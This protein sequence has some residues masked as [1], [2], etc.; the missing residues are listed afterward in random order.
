MET[1]W[2]VADDG[3]RLGYVVDGA[4]PPLVVCHGGPGLADDLGPLAALVHDHVSVVRWDQRGVGRSDPVGPHTIE[5]YVA[6]LDALRRHLGHERWIVG[7]HSFGATIALRYALAH[8]ERTRGLLYLAGVGTG[9]AWPAAAKA[10]GARRLTDEQRARRDALAAGERT[11]AE[12]V[13]WRALHWLPDFVGP[14]AHAHATALAEA[15]GPICWEANRALNAEVRADDEEVVLARCRTLDVP[16][17]L[18]HGA[19]DPRPPWALDTLAAALPRAEVVVVPAA[20]HRPWVEA[21]AAIGSAI[22]R[23][24][25]ARG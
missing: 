4:G 23:W 5:R 22:T 15:S 17:L 13:E 3:V 16:A 21:P 11:P 19:D 20:G 1:G 24:W 7:G 8:P 14:D 25:G 12:E 9:R 18:L 2:A 10:E 6:D